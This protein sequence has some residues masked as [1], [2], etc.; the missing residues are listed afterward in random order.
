MSELLTLYRQLPEN[1]R[2]EFDFAM[3][4]INAALVPESGKQTQPTD[5]QAK[6]PASNDPSNFNFGDPSIWNSPLYK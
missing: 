1:A 2:R 5:A 6:S 4:V 3:T